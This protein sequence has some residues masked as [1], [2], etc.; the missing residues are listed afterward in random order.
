[1]GDLLKFVK[2]DGEQQGNYHFISVNQV[3]ALGSGPWFPP[4]LK[5]LIIL[6]FRANKL[7]EPKKRLCCFPLSNVKANKFQYIT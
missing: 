5:L 7:Y 1:M 3:A 4:I 2:G 6:V